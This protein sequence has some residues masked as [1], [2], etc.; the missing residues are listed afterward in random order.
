MSTAPD[1]PAY[2]KLVVSVHVSDWPGVMNASNGPASAVTPPV[3]V[4][5]TR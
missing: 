2:S 4:S 5:V 1:C 3:F